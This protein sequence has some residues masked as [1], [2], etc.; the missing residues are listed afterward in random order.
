MRRR[1]EDIIPLTE[2]FL[3]QFT[4]Q[5]SHRFRTI[6]SAAAEILLNHSWPGNVRE[7]ENCVAAAFTFSTDGRIAASE[8]PESVRGVRA[9]ERSG[10]H[11]LDVVERMHL[12]RVLQASDY[13]KAEAARRLGIDRTT[14]YRKMKRLGLEPSRVFRDQGR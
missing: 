7:L 14:L 13:N 6:S 12:E 8:L 2:M 5:K 10:E 9:S 1:R 11:S 4:A 3:R